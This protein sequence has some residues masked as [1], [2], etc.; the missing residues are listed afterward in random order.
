MDED[1]DALAAADEMALRDIARTP[2]EWKRCSLCSHHAY[3]PWN[4]SV[5]NICEEY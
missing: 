5:C 1:Y 2:K 4:E 3:M